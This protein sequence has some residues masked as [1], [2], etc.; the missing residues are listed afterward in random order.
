MLHTAHIRMD[1]A[2]VN[3]TDT[4]GILNLATSGEVREFNSVNLYTSGVFIDSGVLHLFTMG[5]TGIQE[6]GLCL[7][8]SG[9]FVSRENINLFTQGPL[10]LQES[11]FNLFTTNHV[12]VQAGSG[13]E[14]G[15]NL[16]ISG[17]PPISTGWMPLSAFN[18]QT[19]NIPD[20]AVLNLST[21]VSDTSGAESI[22]SNLPIFV[23]N[24]QKTDSNNYNHIKS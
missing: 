24:N 16:T 18:V 15:L 8:T 17:T 12:T 13:S 20:G 5:P 9:M 6:S 4:S 19:E 22:Q 10:Q 2:Y 11:G 21:F 7:Y 3:A 1:D 23:L 14:P